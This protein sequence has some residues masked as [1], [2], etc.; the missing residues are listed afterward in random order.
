[1]S[2]RKVSA[3]KQIQFST[4]LL[5]LEKLLNFSAKRYPSFAVHLKKK[6]FTLQIKIRDNSQG[7]F[8]TFKNGRVSS[9]NG[10]HPGADVTMAF[11]DAALACHLMKFNRSQL[12]FIS[13]G[14]D[15]SLT[16]NGPDEL[17]VYVAN[18]LTAITNMSTIFGGNFGTDMGNGVKRYTTGS[19]GGPMFVYVKDGKILRTTPID[20]D[21]EDPEPF[22]INAR[23][24]KF[25]PPR[26]VTCTSHGLTWKSM[27]YSPDRLLYPMKRV[28]FDPKGNRNTQN[29]GISGYERISWDEAL[30]IVSSE[31]ARVKKT[32]GPGSLFF[33]GSSHHTWGNIGYHLSASDRFINTLGFSRICMNPDSWEGFYWGGMHHWGNTAK[34]GSPDQYS[35]VEDQLKNSEMLVMWSS[36]PESTSGAYGTYEG[37]IRRE[38]LKSLDIKI[39][40]I[41]PFYNHTAAWM[42]GKWFSPRPGTDTAMALAIAYVWITQDLYDKFF[43][44]NRTKGFALWRD[45]ILGKEDGIPKTPEWQEKET[46][47][48]AKD[49]RALAEEWGSKKTYMSPGGMAGVGSACRGA[50]GGEWARSMLCLMAMQGFGK[51]G[52]NFGAM[53][54]GTPLNHRFFFPGYAEGGFSG[55]Y[56]FTGSPVNLYQRMPSTPSV[57]SIT[58][59]VPRLRIPEAFLEGHA[60]GYPMNPYSLE[61]QFFPAPYPSPGHSQVKLYYKYG[62]AY[63]S[64]QPESNRYALA[65]Q[66]DNIE[67]VVNQSIWNEGEVRFADIILPVCTNFERWDIGEF[68]HSGG[69][70]D[71]TFLQCNHRTFFV[72]HKCIEPLGESRSDFQIYTDICCRL[73]VGVPYSEGNT[74]FDWVKRMFDATDLPK[75]ISWRKFLTKGYYILP[76]IYDEKDRDPVAYNWFYEGRLKDAPELTPLPSEYKEE[77]RRG[78]QTQSGL[79]E[80]E[81]SSLKRFDP[82]DPERPVINKYVPS[83]EGRSSELYQKYPL[84]LIS[85]HPRYSHH[86]MSDGKGTVINEISNHRIS[87]NGYHYWPVR[88][89]PEDAEKRGIKHHDLVEVYNGRGSVICAAV[90]TQR[91]NPGTVHAYESAAKYDPTGL[92]GK[93]PDRGGLINILTPSRTQIR[94][95]HSMA[96]NSC[97]VEIRLW[98]GDQSK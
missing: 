73:G 24:R 23:G 50:N 53:Q 6:N 58:Q 42:G 84:Q 89:N 60:M 62:G 88:I 61:G 82:N 45:Y 71:K 95:S 87:I 43:V 97:L 8:F 10:V 47:I 12:D 54:F 56:N 41:D 22:T 40:H 34:L 28:D 9:K 38:W 7:R 90:V 93:S 49:V 78:L 55:D 48:P 75:V 81:C 96:A 21:S 77:Y 91:L 39:V 79:F 30:D 68:A 29:R 14:K 74:E 32:H 70:I 18:M 20:L 35:T 16:V 25:T 66:T 1:M 2:F 31:I 59:F 46:G 57:S 65:Y 64:T 51:P 98:K 15:F 67:F 44:E 94:Q 27:V 5:G 72:Q 86:T 3:N 76:P 17:C 69:I 26:R 80:F 37:A 33:A 83:W 36:D 92:P 63:M 13:A 52:V 85:P 19:N 4:T 11:E